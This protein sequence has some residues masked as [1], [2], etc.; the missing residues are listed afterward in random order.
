MKIAIVILNW[1]GR[2]LLQKFLPSIIRYSSPEN[3]DIYVAD[4]ASTDDSIHFIKKNFSSVKIIQNTENWGFAKGY[5][6]ALKKIH[7][8]VYGLINSDIQVTPN[9]L[10]PIYQHFKSDKKAAI[11][12]PKILDFKRKTHFEYAGAAGGFIDKLGYPYC[13]GRVFNTLEKDL[14]QYDESYPIFWGSGACLFIKSSIFNDLGGFDIDFYA[15]QEEIDLCWR[16]QNKGFQVVYIG[17]SSVYHVGGAT[18]NNYHWK[19]TFLNFRNSLFSLTKNAPNY[20]R[21]VFYR[22]VLD[23]VAG[24]KFFLEGKPI[25][26]WAIIK[27][28]FSYYAHFNKMQNKRKYHPIKRNDYYQTKSIVWDYFVKKKKLF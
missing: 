23:G 5:N 4:N 19:K 25:H 10:E 21:L 2:D 3:T 27:A 17:A 28:H 16:A 14:G 20:K 15:H 8:D 12:Q 9:W 6:E 11:V 13:K 26:T 7:A 18:L 24:I 1:N 22:L